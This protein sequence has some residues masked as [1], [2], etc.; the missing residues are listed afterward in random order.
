M[1]EEHSSAGTVVPLHH[2]QKLEEEGIREAILSIEDGQGPQEVQR[3]HRGHG[4]AVHLPCSPPLARKFDHKTL[5]QAR[6]AMVLHE[7]DAGDGHGDEE[8]PQHLV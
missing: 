8:R 4:Y 1:C 6:V 2:P 5:E 7:E 3:Q